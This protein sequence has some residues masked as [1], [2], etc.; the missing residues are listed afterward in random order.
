MH[1][2]KVGKFMNTKPRPIS[3]SKGRGP[4]VIWPCFPWS[5]LLLLPQPPPRL[6]I[7][8]TAFPQTLSPC[9][10]VLVPTCPT[11]PCPFILLLML[12]SATHALPP[13]PSVTPATL[14]RFSCGTPPLGPESTLMHF[15]SHT[16]HNPLSLCN[17][18]LAGCSK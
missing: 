1:V 6:A 11:A 15:Y 8:M 17:H 16:D 3:F 13:E 7:Q 4:F 10:S 12:G 18:S 9:V 14:C 2:Q 5:H